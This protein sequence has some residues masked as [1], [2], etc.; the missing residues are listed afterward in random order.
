MNIN[1]IKYTLID[2][3]GLIIFS[4]PGNIWLWISNGPASQRR[5]VAFLHRHVAAALIH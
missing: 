1:Q 2:I 3:D 5:V 4:S